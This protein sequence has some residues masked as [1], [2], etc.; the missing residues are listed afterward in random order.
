MVEIFIGLGLAIALLFALAPY[1][2]ASASHR[3]PGS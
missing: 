2:P 1:A 3:R